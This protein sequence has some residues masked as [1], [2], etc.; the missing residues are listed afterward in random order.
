MW[1]ELDSRVKVVIVVWLVVLHLFFAG[2]I[3]LYFDVTGG[4]GI[5]SYSETPFEATAAAERLEMTA[6]AER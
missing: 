3:Y 4:Y 1:R 5:G 2:L 6:L